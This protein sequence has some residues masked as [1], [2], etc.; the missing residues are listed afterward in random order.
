MEN[1]A[2]CLSSLHVYVSKKYG[3]KSGS[4]YYQAL[5]VKRTDLRQKPTNQLTLG[6][7]HVTFE[8]KAN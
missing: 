1:Q 4:V 8:G 7:I 6:H 2:G 3:D 5:F